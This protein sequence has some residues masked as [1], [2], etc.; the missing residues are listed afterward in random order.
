MTLNVAHGRSNGVNQVFQ[1]AKRI[2]GNVDTIGALLRREGPDV[3]VLQEADGPSFWSGD[4]DHVSSL[5]E[6]GGF[7]HS[8]HGLNVK[9]AGIAFGTAILSRELPQDALCVTFDPSPPTF[10]KGFV[11]AS[12]PF[13][14]DPASRV[15]VVSVHLDF[16]RKSVR[17]RQVEKMVET[18]EGRNGP[19]VIMGDFNAG[20]KE[21]SPV[22]T[23]ARRLRLKAYEPEEKG[24]ITFPAL[25]TRLDWVLLSEDLEFVSHEILPDVVSDHLAVVAVVRKTDRNGV[26]RKG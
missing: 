16:S 18:L 17:E 20:W 25:K 6:R 5:A 22:Q 19:L 21:G 24:L 23:L 14:D 26:E 1:S 7:S 13:K 4:F 10:S 9:G 8:V 15:T 12:L 3:A 11:S 2:S